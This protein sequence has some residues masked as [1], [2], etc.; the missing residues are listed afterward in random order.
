[1]HCWTAMFMKCLLLF[2][3][4]STFLTQINFALNH[5]SHPLCDK[6]YAL[7]GDIVLDSVSCMLF[8]S[9]LL[10][11]HTISLAKNIVEEGLLFHSLAFHAM[12][13][14]CR[15]TTSI[16]RN[17]VSLRQRLQSQYRNLIVSYP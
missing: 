16:G 17:F 1:M 7:T 5:G 4:A 9:E 2:R 8:D 15:Q 14:M 10:A 3:M 13:L 12:R 11:L 6:E